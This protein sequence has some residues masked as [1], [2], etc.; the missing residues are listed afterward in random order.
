[1]R[2]SFDSFK[3]IVRQS[4]CHENPTAKPYLEEYY[5]VKGYYPTV[6]DLK[7]SATSRIYNMVVDALNDDDHLPRFLVITLD[8]D[9]ISDIKTF[10]YGLTKDL[11]IIMNWLTRKIDILVR[12]KKCQIKARKLGGISGDYD[13]VIIY[14]DM[15]KRPDNKQYSK[16][17]TDICNSRYKFNVVTH[18]TADQQDQRILSICTCNSYSCFDNSG[19]LTNKG[20]LHFW[21]E[22]DELLEMFDDNRVKLLPRLHKT[23]GQ[24]TTRNPA[25][26]PCPSHHW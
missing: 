22:V 3:A 18:E 26:A 17:L 16:R 13:P 5:N 4:K 24:H 10:D 25:T 9:V 14:I 7:T 8:K 2:E 19:N 15:I 11:T 21:H 12:R 20:K 1:M 6:S 23:Y